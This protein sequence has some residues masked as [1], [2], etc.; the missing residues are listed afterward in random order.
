MCSKVARV[1]VVYVYFSKLLWGSSLYAL[2]G[3]EKYQS[4]Y[5]PYSTEANL[6]VLAGKDCHTG[7]SADMCVQ[8]FDQTAILPQSIT[9][10]DKNNN[11]VSIDTILIIVFVFIC[12]LF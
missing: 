4:K 11:F 10:Q 2:K 1:F 5:W 3:V 12:L 6:I 9:T 7:N 8:L